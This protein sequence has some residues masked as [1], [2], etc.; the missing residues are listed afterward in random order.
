LPPGS[1]A[2][3]DRRPPLACLRPQTALELLRHGE[4][5]VG[6]DRPIAVGRAFQIGQ[7]VS[8]KPGLHDF[9]RESGSRLT[10]HVD[11]ARE[12]VSGPG[13]FVGTRRIGA[14]ACQLFQHR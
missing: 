8:V 11:L 4:N 9:S 5:L 3:N 2:V 1:P 13:E 14:K 10:L 12:V 6:R 7:T